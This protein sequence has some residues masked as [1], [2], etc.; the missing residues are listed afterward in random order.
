MTTHPMDKPPARMRQRKRASGT[1]RLWWEPEAA[2]RRMG[3]ETVELDAD[4]PTWS[5]RRAKDLNDQ[6]DRARGGA[7][8]R[9]QARTVNDLIVDYKASPKWSKLKPA[10]RRDY[11]AAFNIIQ[12]KWGADLV[13]NM[14]KSTVIE[15]WE[16]NFHKRGET[17]AGSLHRKL[18]LLL[19]HA[20]MKEWIE[21][22]PCLRMKIPK[23]APRERTVSWAEQDDLILMADQL[24]LG[25]VGTAIILSAWTG[26]RQ[27]DCLN[28]TYDN[29]IAAFIPT[30]LIQRAANEAEIA[31]LVSA[32][33][34]ERITMT[35]FIN[36][37][38]K[39]KT[40]THTALFYLQIRQS[41]RGK[42]IS[43]RLQDEPLNRVMD[44]HNLPAT[45]Q[46]LFF[47]TSN[48]KYASQDQFSKAFARV[49]K[50]TAI[51][52]PSVMAPVIQFRDFR[53]TFS[54]RA[55]RGGISTENIGSAMGN[56]IAT[57]PE[58]EETYIPA[59]SAGASTAAAGIKR[60][61]PSKAKRNA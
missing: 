34:I 43:V 3:F 52:L 46:I 23:P 49:R 4:K 32:Q 19:S 9:P 12:K 22:N 27:T 58:L 45:K 37:G 39:A 11:I 24:G 16:A 61:H 40:I 21:I 29:I 13:I 8:A 42:I 2:V 57:N 44:N 15:W 56:T 7:K 36:T 14:K 33:D 20:E 26:M 6:V 41:K 30:S 38:R 50:H 18:S 5:I 55:R 35:D 28:V 51:K 1:W 25:S 60:P 48:T 47:E 10:T 53:R 59:T 54:S 31:D 17:Q